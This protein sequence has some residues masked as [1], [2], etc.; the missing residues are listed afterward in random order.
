MT[1]FSIAD[2]RNF[3]G[4]SSLPLLAAPIATSLARFTPIDYNKEKPNPN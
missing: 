1:R 4:N 3:G 2:N